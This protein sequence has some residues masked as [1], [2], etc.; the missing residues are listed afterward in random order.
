MP[1]KRRTIVTYIRETEMEPGQDFD[2]WPDPT[3]WLLT[4]WPDPT[5]PDSVVERCETNPRQWLTAVSVTCQETQT[6]TAS[7]DCQNPCFWSRSYADI[8]LPR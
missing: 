6:F 5:R 4:R 1:Q 8:S 7:V 2:Q 3:K